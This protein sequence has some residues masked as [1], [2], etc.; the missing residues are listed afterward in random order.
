MRFHALL[1][2][3]DIG[4]V[5]AE[6]SDCDQL[7]ERYYRIKRVF[8]FLGELEIY[9]NEE[10]AEL[11]SLTLDARKRYELLRDLR[12]INW[13]RGVFKTTERHAYHRFKDLRI[14]RKL[15]LKHDLKSSFQPMKRACEKLHLEIESLAWPDLAHLAHSEDANTAALAIFCPYLFEV[16]DVDFNRQLDFD[17]LTSQRKVLA[18]LS[19][20]PPLNRGNSNLDAAIASIRA[21]NPK[22]AQLFL[23]LNRI[24][25][26]IARAFVRGAQ[27]SEDWHQPWLERLSAGES[28]TV[29]KEMNRSHRFNNPNA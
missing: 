3:L 2:D 17:T 18:L 6:L 16:F 14:L 7:R 13:I 24:E 1:S 5:V 11:S 12:K 27:H 8:R 15:K 4:Y 26:L 22:L 21:L 19:A 29:T 9:A 23:E 20:T 28:V 10:F 25:C